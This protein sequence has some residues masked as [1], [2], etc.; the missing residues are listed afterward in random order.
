MQASSVTILSSNTDEG[1][2]IQMKMPEKS[3]FHALQAKEREKKYAP[4][5]LQIA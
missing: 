3:F 1:L 2:T 4:N 5:R